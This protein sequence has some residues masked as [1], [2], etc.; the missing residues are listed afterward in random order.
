MRKIISAVVSA[1]FLVT[2]T[3]PI[4]SANAD[5]IETTAPVNSYGYQDLNITTDDD[6]NS[7]VKVNFSSDEIQN[8]TGGTLYLKNGDTVLP[9]ITSTSIEGNSVVFNVTEDLLTNY[10]E[11]DVD[12]VELTLSDGSKL[13]IYNKYYYTS[14]SSEGKSILTEIG[15]YLKHNSP[16]SVSDLTLSSNNAILEQPFTCNLKVASEKEAVS[17]VDVYVTF[18]KEDTTP[19]EKT[20]KATKTDDGYS[21]EVVFNNSTETGTWKVS[22][23]QIKD[24][25]NRETNISMGA[26]EFEV[27]SDN[28]D[29]TSP[30]V[31]NLA[32]NELN[33]DA[34]SSRVDP[35]FTADITDDESGLDLAYIS[36]YKDGDEEHRYSATFFKGA[37]G[38]YKATCYTKDLTNGTY[39][40]YD[41][42]AYDK[43]GNKTYIPQ[44]KLSNFSFKISNKPD[45]IERTFNYEVLN[46]DLTK[47]YNAED[48]IKFNMTVKTSEKITTAWFQDYTDHDYLGKY[49]KFKIDDYSQN[50]DGT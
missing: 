31:E 48:E 3:T 32:L 39:Y 27:V 12:R 13:A 45:E 50:E 28:T 2:L 33:Y 34:N 38:H 37:D 43:A 26:K 9:A 30:K 21:A 5:S 11:Y 6:D 17:P 15:A 42:Y 24:N 29:I 22:N 47:S 8:I 1:V 35:Y 10:G 19:N 44:D 20:I 23:V 14:T 25:T 18:T 46:Y 41:L 40:V 4:I 36:Y 16:L 49:I 7:T